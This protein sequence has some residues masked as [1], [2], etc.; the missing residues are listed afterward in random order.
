MCLDCCPYLFFGDIKK[1]GGGGSSSS[2]SGVERSAVPKAVLQYQ[3][4]I[5]TR[6]VA[7]WR[8]GRQ[9]LSLYKFGD[10]T[11]TT[12]TFISDIYDRVQQTNSSIQYSTS[13]F[14]VRV[15]SFCFAIIFVC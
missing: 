5:G 6:S 11:V 15:R 12:R 4:Y 2:S 8:E 9:H 3:S 10:S 1:D 13:M 7:Q 14:F